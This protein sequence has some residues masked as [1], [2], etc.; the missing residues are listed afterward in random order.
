MLSGF[1][2]AGYQ[3]GFG[4]VAY[5]TAALTPLRYL[6]LFMI[7]VLYNDWVFLLRRCDALWANIDVA[8]KK[9]FDLLPQLVDTAK[10]Y[11]AHEQGVQEQLA[12]LRTTG[13]PPTPE[14]AGEMVASEQAVLNTLTGVVEDYPDLK[15]NEVMRDL[16]HRIRALEDDVALMREGYNHA[17]ETYKI[18]IARIPELI[19]AR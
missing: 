9:R 2:L 1:S 15:G 19:L 5:M 12:A 11:L 4:A 3:G 6:L 13:S 10:A 8:L 17:V 16:M 18:R 7:A 14:Q